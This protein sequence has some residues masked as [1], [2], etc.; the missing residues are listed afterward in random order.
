VLK[1]TLVF[2][3]VRKIFPYLLQC[4]HTP[5]RKQNRHDFLYFLRHLI[6]SWKTYKYGNNG[7]PQML[8]CVCARAGGVAEYKRLI[9]MH[10]RGHAKD[11]PGRELHALLFVCAAHLFIYLLPHREMVLLSNSGGGGGETIFIRSAADGT[12]RIIHSCR[13]DEHASAPTVTNEEAYIV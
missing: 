9:N 13:A 3:F 11:K 2:W 5:R 4:E 7:S 8:A 1:K 10:L 6:L 12:I